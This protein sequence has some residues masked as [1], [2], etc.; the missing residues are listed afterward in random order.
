MDQKYMKSEE[1]K[2]LFQSDLQSI[3][4]IETESLKAD[5]RVNKV[6]TPVLLSS[7]GKLL[8]GY[9]CPSSNQCRL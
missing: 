6:L 7:D 2:K 8:D 3:Y 1:L 4:E 9:R 5:V